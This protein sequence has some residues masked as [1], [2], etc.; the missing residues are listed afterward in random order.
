M[1]GKRGGCR[2]ACVVVSMEVLIDLKDANASFIFYLFPQSWGLE[3]GLFTLL[4]LFFKMELWSNPSWVFVVELP[5][6]SEHS[7]GLWT[8][9]VLQLNFHTPLCQLIYWLGSANSTVGLAR[10]CQLALNQ[11]CWAHQLNTT[12]HFL[13]AHICC[14]LTYRWPG[15]SCAIARHY[16][17]LLPGNADASLIMDSWNG[18]FLKRLG[19]DRPIVPVKG[20]C[21]LWLHCIIDAFLFP[22]IWTLINSFPLF[23]SLV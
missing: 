14:P 16:S 8:V 11:L 20:S 6:R 10:T 15:A 12:P 17:S 21:A 13:L 7:M 5:K 22:A 3:A 23:H 2:T 1:V 18:H 19:W 9:L 4:L